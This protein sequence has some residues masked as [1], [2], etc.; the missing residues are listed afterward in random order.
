[1][2]KLPTLFQKKTLVSHMGE[3]QKDLDEFVAIEYLMSWFDNRIPIK[4]KGEAKIK[5]VTISDRVIILLSGTGSGKSTGIPP[6]LFLRFSKRLNKNILITQP[7]VLTAIEI[8]KT[9]DSIPAY[10]K[11]NED[12]LTVDLY[13]NMG[14]QTKEFVRRTPR[15][16]LFTTTGILLQFL[17]NMNTSDFINKYAF[18]LIDEVHDRSLE[19]DL[20]LKL[21]KD[22]IMN[23]LNKD[24]PF[25]ILMSA[26]LNIKTF[27][28]YF[29]TKTIFEVTGKSYNIDTHFQKYDTQN[30]ITSTSELVKNIHLD[31]ELDFLND[32]KINYNTNCDILIFVPGMAIMKKLNK[33]IEKLNTDFQY[34]IIVINLTSEKF[35]LAGNDYQNIFKKLHNINIEINEKKIHPTRRVIISTNIAETGV[36]IESL[37]YCIDLGFVTA[38]EYNPNLNCKF[39]SS[40]A[41]T[42]SMAI[43]RKGRVGRVQ[44]GVWHGMYTEKTFNELQI[45]SYP[46]IYVE[47]FT[48]SL[49]S[50]LSKVIV[51]IVEK[52][53]EMR[54][55]EIEEINFNNLSKLDLSNLDLLSN[56]SID[57][58]DNCL[59]KL[60]IMGAIYSNNYITPMGYMFLKLRKLNIEC[61]RML[62][63]SFIYDDINYLDI[64]TIVS[65]L[66]IGKKNVVDNKFRNWNINFI[67]NKDKCIDYYNYNKLKN[68]LY[69]SCE[70]IEFLL[71][72]KQFTK[73]LSENK[74]ETVKEWCAINKIL[75]SG[76][77]TI[78]QMRDD[79]IKELL[80]NCGLNPFKNSSIDILELLEIDHHIQKKNIK[81][82][83][84]TK[85]D[86]NTSIQ[87]ISKIKH[88][89]YEGFKLNLAKLNEDGEYESINEHVIINIKSSL[90]NNLPIPQDGE[91]FQQMKPKY[92]IYSNILLSY[93]KNINSYEFNAGDCISILDGYVNYDYTFNI[94]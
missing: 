67:N 63:T 8:P 3:K 31:N 76:M 5:T 57:T 58:L 92:I 47:E 60:Y 52:D 26:T 12:G 66:T 78:I 11:P 90:T 77:M 24:C 44:P 80:F 27:A 64:V 61:M 41:V 93:N 42:Q 38:L 43:Q 17:K 53:E 19:V 2:S 69:I 84:S 45:D 94:S 14:Y 15:G 51:S 79:I 22:L 7:R 83:K 81:G 20:V 54:F 70:F 82:G 37:K 62:L 86:F 87:Y 85:S 30:Y 25:I 75:F 36:T 91:Q 28:N 68:R 74:I 55:L 71:V 13:T 65:Y 89:I 40:K 16:I 59:N 29:G 88:C 18:I 4:Y 56:P 39:L 72:F 32:K 33:A 73:L 9:I 10:K 23:N 34:P 49:L 35:K 6:N 1:M 50:I 21:L 48:L 46:N